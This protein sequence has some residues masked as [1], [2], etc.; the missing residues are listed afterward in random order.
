MLLSYLSLLHPPPESFHAPVPASSIVLAGDSTG[1]ALCL[2]LLQLL[3]HFKRNNT[4][5]V[6][7]YESL[8]GLP[9]P[10]GLSV[11]S[12]SCD[13]TDSLPSFDNT[14][15]VDYINRAPVYTESGFPPCSIWPTDPPRARAYS[16]NAALC[17]PL[18]SVALA[19]CWVGSPPMWFACGEEAVA[20][21]CKIVA[22]RA[23]E[24]GVTVL[25]EE[26]MGMPH[27]FPLL[28]GMGHV[29][30]V[31]LCLNDWGV[32][33]QRCVSQPRSL[34]KSRAIQVDYET[35]KENE[36]NLNHLMSLDFQEVKER[37][38]QGMADI[39]RSF[40]KHQQ[41]QVKL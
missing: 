38:N 31:K 13:Q 26:Y 33:C 7:F 37:M 30:Q 2:A 41:T 10:A 23:S 8:V 28:M 15:H 24:Q 35:C 4:T 3:L 25:F 29:P 20:D 9:L 22:K 32:F 5:T 11:L 16:E 19:D 18:I 12:P 21:G 17:H 14:R 6:R 1:G 27:T 34:H 36:V 40:R 39:E